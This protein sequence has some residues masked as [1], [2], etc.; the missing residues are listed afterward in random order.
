MVFLSSK[1]RKH[2][3][4]V[5]YVLESSKTINSFLEKLEIDNY[6]IVIQDYGAPVGFR[7]ALA[8]PERVTAIITQNGNAYEEGIGEAWKP[9]KKLWAN[10]IKENEEA[11]YFF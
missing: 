8:H 10:R 11:L 6:A 7:I 2:T 9:I 4:Y 1:N 5:L 3:C